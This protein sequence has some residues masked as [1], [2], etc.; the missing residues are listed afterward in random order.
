MPTQLEPS[1]ETTG[2]Q[3]ITA[4]QFREKLGLS[5]SSWYRHIITRMDCPQPIMILPGKQ[6]FRLDEVNTFIEKLSNERPL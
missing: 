4:K 2:P 6:R 5:S 3:L 1:L